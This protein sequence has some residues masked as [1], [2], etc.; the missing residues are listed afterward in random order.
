[1]TG[2]NGT[3]PQWVHLNELPALRMRP[4]LSGYLPSL[5]RDTRRTATHLGNLW[6]PQESAQWE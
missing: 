1:M 4:P 5:A 6:R 3:S 2:E